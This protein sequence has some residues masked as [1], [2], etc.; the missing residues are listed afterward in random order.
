MVL[1]CGL[2][3]VLIKAVTTVS[4]TPAFFKEIIWSA[5]RWYLV[6]EFWIWAT[7]TESLTWSCTMVWTSASVGPG[8]GVA[9][10]CVCVAHPLNKSPANKSKCRFF[11]VKMYP[12]AAYPS[13]GARV[14]LKKMLPRKL[15]RCLKLNTLHIAWRNRLDSGEWMLLSRVSPF[16]CQGAD[17]G[18][19]SSCL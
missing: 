2:L 4:L 5:V 10:G 12:N 1:G 19:K 7:I 11:M 17:S 15:F 18:S 16:A 8:G 13:N 6:L 3:A 9:A 14:C